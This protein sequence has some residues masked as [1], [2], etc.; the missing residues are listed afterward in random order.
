MSQGTTHTTAT[1][2]VKY[3]HNFVTMVPDIVFPINDEVMLESGQNTHRSSS[4]IGGG[5]AEIDKNELIRSRIEQAK[6]AIERYKDY[7][8][9]ASM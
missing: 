8:T 4:S 1:P 5:L 9:E 7:K 3:R 2:N 6:K